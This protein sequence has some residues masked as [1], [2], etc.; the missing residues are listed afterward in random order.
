MKRGKTVH[1]LLEFLVI[2][3]VFKFRPILAMRQADDSHGGGVLTVVASFAHD[4]PGSGGR[5]LLK[6][7]PGAP[8]HVFVLNAAANLAKLGVAL[9]LGNE[10]VS[11]A[12]RASDQGS[13]GLFCAVDV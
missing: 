4:V 2:V 6:G 7:T 13:A 8:L 11:V 9:F 5:G 3:L 12:V 10:G 1:L